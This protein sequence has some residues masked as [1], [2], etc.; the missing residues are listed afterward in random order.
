M[1]LLTLQAARLLVCFHPACILLHIKNKNNPMLL[2]ICLSCQVT[3]S[4]KS[5]IRIY[6]CLLSVR[7]TRSDIVALASLN[8]VCPRMFPPRWRYST[9]PSFFPPLMCLQVFFLWP[10]CLWNWNFAK[11]LV[12]L[13][14]LH[15]ICWL[16]QNP[17]WLPLTVQ[18][19]LTFT[20]G[21]ERGPFLNS[22]R[23][24][25]MISVYIL[26]VRIFHILI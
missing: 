14:T 15:M 4:K 12:A 2:T 25:I 18:R 5:L 17:F 13:K 26:C 9:W 23:G 6:F 3:Q 7:M 20:L 24:S 11:M 8:I 22:N 1:S 21:C 16:E 10:F 19:V